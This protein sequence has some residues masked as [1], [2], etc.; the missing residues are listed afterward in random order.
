MG[1]PCRIS[2]PQQPVGLGAHGQGDAA[3]G[4]AVS[5]ISDYV[6]LAAGEESF[7]GAKLK[8]ARLISLARLFETNKIRIFAGNRPS[9]SATEQDWETCTGYVRELARTAAEYGIYTI[10]ETHPN[11]FA[12]GLASTLR[13]IRQ[14][15]H[16]FL[17]INLDILH[18]W[19]AGCEPLAAMREL[20]PWTMNY[21]LKNVR[22]RD[23]LQVFDPSNVY[24]PSGSREG[25][26]SLAEGAVDFV[27]VIRALR[28]A[29][30]AHSASLEWFG[31]EPYRFLRN[32]LQWLLKL[33][34]D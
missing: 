27:P 10:I 11:T 8:W 20:E 13:L 12:D 14:T 1:H 32:E 16:D 31:Q 30:Y 24:S 34:D 25:M 18:L 5:M 15:E 19:E 28:Q 9:G 22:S 2:L 33:T 21:H 6:D 7:I 17:G 4:I 29:R 3:S 26:V 23:K